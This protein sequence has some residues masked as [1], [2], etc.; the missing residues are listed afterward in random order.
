MSSEEG[1]SDE[2]WSIEDYDK[3]MNLVAAEIYETTIQFLR[4][5]PNWKCTEMRIRTFPPLPSQVRDEDDECQRRR[6]G[7]EDESR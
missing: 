3:D 4:S 2:T 5:L 7:E 1:G 6:V